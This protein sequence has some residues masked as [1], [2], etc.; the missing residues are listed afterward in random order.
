EIPLAL[1]EFSDGKTLDGETINVDAYIKDAA[2]NTSEE[3][4]TS[5][6][7][8]I[9][10]PPAPIIT[11]LELGA[12]G[13]LDGGVKGNTEAGATITDKDEKPLKDENGE[14]LKADENGDFTIPKDSVPDDD[15]IKAKDEAGNESIPVNILKLPPIENALDAVDGNGATI[16][17]AENYEQVAYGE[18]TNDSQPLFEIPIQTDDDG[19]PVLDVNGIPIING[20]VVNTTILIINGAVVDASL[21]TIDGKTYLQ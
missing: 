17:G 18:H 10:P 1:P 8:D 6:D 12:D 7:V 19:N 16:V 4:S 11:E 20:N 15:T 5:A 2:G 13:N 9:T 3:A 14:D 21:V